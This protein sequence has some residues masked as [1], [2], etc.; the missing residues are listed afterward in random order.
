VSIIAR[1]MSLYSILPYE[2]LR[3]HPPRDAGRDELRAWIDHSIQCALALDGTPDWELGI[4]IIRAVEALF[5]ATSERWGGERDCVRME[6]L[7]AK[8]H[9][10]LRDDHSSEFLSG[11]DR[12]LAMTAHDGC[13]GRLELRLL[14]FKFLVRA[15]WRGDYARCL[16]VWNDAERLLAAT[17]SLRASDAYVEF[18]ETMAQVAWATPDEAMLRRI[19]ARLGEIMASEEAPRELKDRAWRS[20]ARYFLT[21]YRDAAELEMRLAVIADLER[22]IG[23][24][25]VSLQMLKLPM[26]E[27]IGR[28]EELRASADPLIPRLRERGMLRQYYQ[29]LVFRICIDAWFDT[30]MD[31]LIATIHRLR[32]EVPEPIRPRFDLS[33]GDRLVRQA[34]LRGAYKAARGVVD[35]FFADPDNLAP[36]FHIMLGA[37]EGR[38]REVLRDIIATGCDYPDLLAMARVVIEGADDARREALLEVRSMCAQPMLC[39]EDFVNFAALL[40]MIMEA[41]L[42]PAN[43][44]FVDELRGDISS[45]LTRGCEWLAA[46]NLFGVL[47]PVLERY[48]RYLGDR[49]LGRWRARA[50]EIRAAYEQRERSRS[51]DTRI[52]IVMLGTIEVHRRG[53]EPV[54]LRGARLRN[55]LGL[56]VANHMLEKPLSYREFC[57]LGAGGEEDHERARKMVSMALLRLRESIGSDVIISNEGETPMLDLDRVHV[58]LIDAHRMLGEALRSARRGNLARALSLLIDAFA[59]TRSEVPFPTLY[60]DFFEAMREDFDFTIREGV[61]QIGGGL[62]REGDPVGA[63]EALRRGFEAMPEDEEI[64]AMLCQALEGEGKR[65]E[66]E[67]IRLRI[68]EL[69]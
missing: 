33:V 44:E 34:V 56:M 1:G 5:E 32:Q 49:E 12:L 58:D 46:R 21:L 40:D 35:I 50:S 41:E 57:R 23:A 62:L 67:R 37:G 53:E 13:A 65:S 17:P 52:G 45:F 27:S 14:A 25:D 61:I 6:I 55:V 29:A 68:A 60:D 11:V 39:T 19:D 47:E 22:K 4:E 31:T 38:L 2:L 10:T 7:V 30:P 8:L 15:I 36:H 16:E 9:L 3:D 66:A 42:D 69:T 54:R 18:M 51:L 43:A 59:L 26:L 24:H 63:E 48:G 20:I 28:M 64:I